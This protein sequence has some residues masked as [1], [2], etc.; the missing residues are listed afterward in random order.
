V[1]GLT[2]K[3]R[4]GP[5]SAIMTTPPFFGFFLGVNTQ[6]LGNSAGNLNLHKCRGLA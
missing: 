4:G 5:I 2:Y 1:G 3:K 6:P